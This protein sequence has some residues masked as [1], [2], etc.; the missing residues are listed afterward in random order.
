[1]KTHTS[2]HRNAVLWSVFAGAV[3]G[4]TLFVGS[5]ALV[6]AA[7]RAGEKA[8]ARP[9]AYESDIRPL[10]AA[11]CFGCHGEDKRKARLDLRGKE[12]RLKGGESGPALVPGSAE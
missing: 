3:G 10:L 9:I 8:G 4:V 2:D 12:P 6:P 5:I 1:M 11:A 7:A